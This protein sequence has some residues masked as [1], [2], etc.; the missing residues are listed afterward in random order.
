MKSVS[1]RKIQRCGFI[2]RRRR[3]SVMVS[4][5]QVAMKLKAAFENNSNAQKT[6]KRNHGDAVIYDDAADALT[7]R[8][9][10]DARSG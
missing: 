1:E 4:S 5:K 10:E 3:A 2:C 9:Q 7:E 8:N 6:Y